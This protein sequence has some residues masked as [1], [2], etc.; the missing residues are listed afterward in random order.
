MYS[1]SHIGMNA[2]SMKT[3]FA[4]MFI[5]VYLEHASTPLPSFKWFFYSRNKTATTLRTTLN[6][7]EYLSSKSNTNSQM[8]HVHTG[9][10]LWTGNNDP[11]HH[12]HH[13]HSHLIWI[14]NSEINIIQ[15]INSMGILIKNKL[16]ATKIT[17]NVKFFQ[18]IHRIC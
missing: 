15:R 7:F 16:F 10:H 17:K 14:R 2:Q 13:H 18:I 5:H 6:E 11:H 3:P 8:N 1:L 4:C 9:V 12:H